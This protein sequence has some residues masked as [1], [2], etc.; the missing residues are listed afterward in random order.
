MRLLL[1]HV[2]AKYR[3]VALNFLLISVDTVWIKSFY[4]R[5][6]SLL[7]EAF[8]VWL[9][10]KHHFSILERLSSFWELEWLP[11]LICPQEL[12]RVGWFQ[13]N[14]LG[15]KSV[16]AASFPASVMGK[17]CVI[18]L[19]FSDNCRLSPGFLVR[20]RLVPVQ[21][22]NVLFF[23]QFVFSWSWQ[24]IYL[25]HLALTSTHMECGHILGLPI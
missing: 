13:E 5:V 18:A 10:K 20:S 15:S 8:L 6:N 19:L 21:C 16:S 2:K 14:S 25:T 11:L 23:P 7:P 12:K 17:C 9:E 22:G 4:L 24:E 1:F 3:K